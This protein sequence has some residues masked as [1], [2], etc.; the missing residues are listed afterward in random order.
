MDKQIKLLYL[1]ADGEFHSGEDL[2]A[3]LSVTRAAI[4]KVIK[5][6][7]GYGLD[8]CSV[9]G[10]GYRLSTAIEFLDRERLL[11]LLKPDVAELI[12]SLEIYEKMETCNILLLY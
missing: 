1:M 3:A 9:R 10:K 4:W 6:L 11:T 8:I 12:D 5:S 2:G 7:R